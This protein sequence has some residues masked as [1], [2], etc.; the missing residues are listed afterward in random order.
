MLKA[1]IDKSAAF[2]KLGQRPSEEPWR[3]CARTARRPS[4]GRAPDLRGVR[5]HDQRK[6]QV[7]PG[8]DRDQGDPGLHGRAAAAAPPAPP[9]P[10]Y[11]WSYVPTDDANGPTLLY[12]P[13]RR[14]LRRKKGQEGADAIDNLARRLDAARASGH[15]DVLK[16]D[17]QKERLAKL[18]ELAA[19]EAEADQRH[20]DRQGQA[21]RVDSHLP[22]VRHSN[23][24]FRNYQRSGRN[25]RSSRRR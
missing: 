2:A 19:Q 17:L 10:A 7:R 15:P 21:A 23:K 3:G 16:V 4:R 8:E 24:P 13:R 25:S 18:E 6:T 9:S 20:K 12:R 14:N 1:V 11:D 5:G 22:N